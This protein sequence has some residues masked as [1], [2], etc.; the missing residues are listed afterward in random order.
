MGTFSLSSDNE[1]DRLD[2]DPEL[3]VASTNAILWRSRVFLLLVTMQ[4]L[5]RPFVIATILLALL[6]CQLG[7]GRSASG[8]LGTFKTDT[9]VLAAGA[10]QGIS[11]KKVKKPMMMDTNPSHLGCLTDFEIWVSS[12]SCEEFLTNYQAQVT[13]ILRKEG[14][15]IVRY[16][17][18]LGGLAAE[19]GN[20]RY[21]YTRLREYGLVRVIWGT[22]APNHFEIIVV[23]D[24]GSERPW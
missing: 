17:P 6:A 21:C 18:L 4:D 20:F 7:C 5:K 11:V 15:S 16:E 9:L 3:V 1:L 14:A 12:G 19:E 8:L 22:H 2:A 10:S 24:E 23:F 13:T